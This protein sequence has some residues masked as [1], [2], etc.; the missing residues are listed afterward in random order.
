MRTK[1]YWLTDFIR[2][3]TNIGFVG[4]IPL[5]GTIPCEGIEDLLKGGSFVEF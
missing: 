3:L 1:K 2:I 5:G 4:I